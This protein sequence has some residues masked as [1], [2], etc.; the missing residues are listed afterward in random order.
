M[1]YMKTVTE[2]SSVGA[3]RGVGIRKCINALNIFKLVIKKLPLT[4][5]RKLAAKEKGK[6]KLSYVAKSTYAAKTEQATNY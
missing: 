6:L 2:N 1:V 5:K 4:L 3:H